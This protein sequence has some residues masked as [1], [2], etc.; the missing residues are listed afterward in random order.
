MFVAKSSAIIAQELDQ[1]SELK[2]IHD[3]IKFFAIRNETTQY[4][5]HH[6][7]ISLF[8]FESCFSSSTS[9]L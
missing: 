6:Q 5:A 9:F 1:T 7:I 8:L 3:S 2:F 4:A